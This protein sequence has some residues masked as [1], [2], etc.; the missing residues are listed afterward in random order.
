MNLGKHTV[1]VERAAFIADA[2][3]N[4]T[5]DWPNAVPHTVT[6][7]SVQPLTGPEVIVG[8]DTIVSRW[9]IFA[10]PGADLLATDRVVYAGD[11]YDVDGEVQRYD[12]PPLSHLVAL[13]RR[14]ETA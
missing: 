13:L 6:G 3:N 1:T 2:F 12:F 5:R 11:T 4:Q 7:C 10:P 9:Q 14:N 8:R